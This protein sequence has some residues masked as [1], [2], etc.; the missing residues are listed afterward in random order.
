M[1]QNSLENFLPKDAIHY[2]HQWLKDEPIRLKVLPS[3]KTKLGDYRYLINEQ[4]HQITLDGNLKPDAFFFV[5]THEIAHMM[6]YNQFKNRVLSHGKEWQLMFGKML[7]ES[8]E[9][10][11]KNLRPYIYRHALKPKASVGADRLLNQHLFVDPTDWDKWVEKL[12]YGQK[13]RLGKRI[14]IRGEK[15]KIRYICREV[16]TN[17]LYLVNGQAVVDEIIHS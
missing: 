9:I 13:F 6:V 8:I 5:F 16:K 3:R 15:Q 2:I 12:P 4:K 10:Y 1:N 14:Y 7:L 11:P 17:K